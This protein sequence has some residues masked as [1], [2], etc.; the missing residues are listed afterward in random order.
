MTDFC[1]RPEVYFVYSSKPSWK[2]FGDGYAT[3]K[4]R[5][6][7]DG[8]LYCIFSE[9]PEQSDGSLRG[10]KEVFITIPAKVVE[11]I[12]NGHLDMPKAATALTPPQPKGN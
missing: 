9:N 7:H 2:R 3:G 5:P 11:M 6:E 4:I 1:G 10:S 8:S 12:K